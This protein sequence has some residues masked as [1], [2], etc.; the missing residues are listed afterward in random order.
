MVFFDVVF[1]GCYQA[2]TLEHDDW[3][4]FFFKFQV[5]IVL[6]EDG[7]LSLLNLLSTE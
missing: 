6:Q 4:Q 3:S 5:A 7:L 2:E 1:E